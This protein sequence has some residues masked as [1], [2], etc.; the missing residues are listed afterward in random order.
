[1]ALLGE[2]S[3][4]LPQPCRPIKTEVDEKIGPA[5][6]AMIGREDVGASG[7]L[8]SWRRML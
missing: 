7:D 5:A 6:E 1:M 3:H 4:H 2:V 8:A